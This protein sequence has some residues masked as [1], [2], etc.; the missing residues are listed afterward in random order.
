[1][2]PRTPG[3]RQRQEIE[4]RAMLL[5]AVWDKHASLFVKYEERVAGGMATHWTTFFDI[6]GNEL[7]Y[8]EGEKRIKAAKKRYQTPPLAR[9]FGKSVFA[10][11]VWQEKLKKQGEFYKSAFM[12]QMPPPEDPHIAAT[13]TSIKIMEAQGRTRINDD[14]ADALRYA[15]DSEIMV[16]MMDMTI[17]NIITT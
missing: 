4:T 8:G 17:K 5:D 1:M 3:K 16:K 12:N 7:P 14:A 15:V 10:S 2:P 11:K 9:G 6:N 13:A